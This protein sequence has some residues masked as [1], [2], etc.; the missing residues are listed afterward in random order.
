MKTF[1]GY[2]FMCVQAS[3]PNPWTWTGEKNIRTNEPFWYDDDLDAWEDRLQIAASTM[4]LEQHPD[5][6]ET[7]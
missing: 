6:E 4:P 1:E 7:A 3:K 5:Y 2:P